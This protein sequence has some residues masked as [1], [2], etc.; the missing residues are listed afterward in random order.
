VIS[1]LLGEK[2]GT[3]LAMAYCPKSRPLLLQ[4]ALGVVIILILVEHSDGFASVGTKQKNHR[5]YLVASKANQDENNFEGSVDWDAEFAKVRKEIGEGKKVGVER[6]TKEFQ[7]ENVE[8]SDISKPPPENKA[9]KELMAFEKRREIRLGQDVEDTKGFRFIGD[10][11]EEERDRRRQLAVQ[12]DLEMNVL[13]FFSSG[14]AQLGGAISLTFFFGWM[15]LALANG[16]LKNVNTELYEA[17][18][19]PP[20]VTLTIDEDFTIQ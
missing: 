1:S 18:Y 10:L 4:F 15:A 7:E 5:S 6:I 3:F 2:K 17:G 16:E 9:V 8:A 12:T 14:K 11:E 13:N 20:S 19:R